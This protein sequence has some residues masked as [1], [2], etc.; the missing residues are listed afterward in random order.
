MTRSF[1]KVSPMQ[2]PGSRISI[3]LAV[4]TPSTGSGNLYCQW[5]LSPGSGNALCILFPTVNCTK[6]NLDNKSVND[7]LI[8]E[9]ERYKEQV[10]ILK[11]G[12]N[13][14][15]K[16][17]DNILDSCAQSVEI[18]HLK[19]TLLEH[20]KEK[21]SLMQMVNLLKND[22]KKEKSRNIDGEITLE[23][24]IKHL[25]NIVFKREML[26]VDIAPLA[27]KLRNNRTAH[28][29]Y[30]R[31]T[32]EQIAILREIVKHGNSLNPLNNSLDYAC[33]ITTTAE[34]PLRKLIAIESDTLKPVVGISYETSVAHSL[35]QN[36]VI[37]RRNH[38]L[39]EAA[40]TMLIY[41]KAPLF[42]WAEAVATACYTQNHSIVRLR[43]GKTPYELLHDKLLDL[44]FFHVFGALCYPANDSKNLEKL[45][46]KADIGIFIG[47]APTKKAFSIYNRL[48]RRI[49]ET[50][51]VNFDELTVMA[52]EHSS[53]GPAPHEMT[54]ATISSGLVPN[55]TSSTPFVPPSRTD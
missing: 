31:H 24:R 27:P 18:D 28:S 12:Q 47:Y 32:Q 35:Q 19:Q 23:Q 26:N 11:E 25:D 44:S 14:D 4:G 3:L 50:I 7:T 39:I 6:I 51:H 41:A 38:T 22:F 1:V 46:P 37:E 9:L 30:I 45:H 34:V 15:L 52:F 36:G 43:Y 40:H 33:K 54:P 2:T 5:E 16:N 20:L 55:P 10:R 49:I 29:D 53:L 48:T 13:V 42:L 8:A 21:E 17:K